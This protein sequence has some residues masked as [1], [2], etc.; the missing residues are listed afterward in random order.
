MYY[1]ISWGFVQTTC[2]T[3][4]RLVFSCCDQFCWY[5]YLY[6]TEI[7]CGFLINGA[8]LTFRTKSFFST[9]SPPICA[10]CFQWWSQYIFACHLDFLY[11]CKLPSALYPHCTK[12]CSTKNM[13]IVCVNISFF[14]SELKHKVNWTEKHKPLSWP[15]QSKL[16]IQIIRIK[17][18][19]CSNKQTNI[20]FYGTGT[21]QNSFEQDIRCSEWDRFGMERITLCSLFPD[22]SRYIR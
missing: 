21:A 7:V 11:N 2:T 5:W 16:I 13:R 15:Q 17:M 18:N 22:N 1:C 6:R 19:C 12:M 14:G 4:L 9:V 8:Y 10:N 20:T 3:L